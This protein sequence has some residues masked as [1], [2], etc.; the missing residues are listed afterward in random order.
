MATS[1]K[2]TKFVLLAKLF[3][4]GYNTEKEIMAIDMEKALSIKSVTMADLKMIA[5]LQKYIKANKL[6]IFLS[7]VDEKKKE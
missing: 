5:E 3:N 2:N 1:N 6:I 7:G 4:E